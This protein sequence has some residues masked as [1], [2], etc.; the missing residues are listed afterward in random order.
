[1]TYQ[2]LFSSFRGA[3]FHHLYTGYHIFRKRELN[4]F[5]IPINLVKGVVRDPL[6]FNT[7][8]EILKGQESSPSI[9]AFN[10]TVLE[11]LPDV[12]VDLEGE[13]LTRRRETSPRSTT[14][15]GSGFTS[16][17]WKRD[18]GKLNPFSLVFI[19]IIGIL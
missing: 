11:I 18:I 2:T 12:D 9:H 6:T 5:H 3:N 8:K 13:V 14:S 17:I 16:K 19:P 1:M 7:F 15:F 10:L 4:C